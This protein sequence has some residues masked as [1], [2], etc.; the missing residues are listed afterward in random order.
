MPLVVCVV[1]I[2]TDL[3][4]CGLL[5]LCSQFVQCIK[6]MFVV[7]NWPLKHGIRNSCNSADRTSSVVE[8]VGI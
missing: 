5:I 3:A 8:I 6:D 7:H 1:L 2:C 4:L